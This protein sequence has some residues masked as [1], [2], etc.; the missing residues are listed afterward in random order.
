MS[1][2]SLPLGTTHDFIL[3]VYL[4]VSA[5]VSVDMKPAAMDGRVEVGAHLGGLHQV[6]RRWVAAVR[7]EDL[8]LK[9]AFGQALNRRQGLS[10]IAIRCRHE[11]CHSATDV[12]PGEHLV[13]R[14]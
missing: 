1:R 3:R 11:S 6:T 2:R 14:P 12:E 4:E 5:R 7:I 8:R 13:A 10:D 9:A